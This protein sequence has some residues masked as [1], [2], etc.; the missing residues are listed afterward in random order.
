MS[1]AALDPM[2]GI[3][4]HTPRY[5]LA[6][7]R[8]L[9]VAEILESPRGVQKDRRGI[10]RTKWAQIRFWMIIQFHRRNHRV[11]YFADRNILAGRKMVSAVTGAVH[12]A[13]DV[14]R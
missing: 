3:I 14:P 5:D 9:D 11:I 8:E 1:V 12:R 7:R 13:Y 2:S 4:F 10:V 6:Q